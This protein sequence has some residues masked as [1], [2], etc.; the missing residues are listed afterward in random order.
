MG[1]KQAVVWISGIFIQRK[2]LKLFTYMTMMMKFE[3]TCTTSKIED[4]N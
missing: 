1:F 4:K 2:L 3:T